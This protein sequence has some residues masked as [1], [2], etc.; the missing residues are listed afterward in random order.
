MGHLSQLLHWKAGAQ[1]IR[2]LIHHEEFRAIQKVSEA[3]KSE[4]AI[5]RPGRH[6]HLDSPGSGERVDR[7][8]D[9][10][11]FEG[12]DDHRVALTENPVQGRIDG[13]GGIQGED[14]PSGVSGKREELCDPPTTSEGDSAGIRR[15]AVSASSR[16]SSVLCK[17]RED[18]ARDGVRAVSRSGSEIE[19][20][21]REILQPGERGHSERERHSRRTN[22]GRGSLPVLQEE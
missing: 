16:G 12:G 22:P 13:V 14:D 7:P 8:K 10:V 18:R 20:V 1:N 15:S 4:G 19:I 5:G 6:P 2:H 17:K 11:M 21:H 9:G 3:F